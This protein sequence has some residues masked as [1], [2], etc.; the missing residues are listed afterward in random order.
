MLHQE[1]IQIL[2]RIPINNIHR[3]QVNDLKCMVCIECFFLVN[4]QLLYRIINFITGGWPPN[5]GNSQQYRQYPPQGP[6]QW[7][8]QGPRL[9][10]PPN[11]WDQNRYPPNQQYGP[12]S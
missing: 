5:S 8:N 12:V 9:P 2:Q 6:Q 10:Q 7:Q 11:Q 4:W 1:D 3:M